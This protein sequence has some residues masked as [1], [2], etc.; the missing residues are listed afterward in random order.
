MITKSLYNLILKGK[1]TLIDVREKTELIKEGEISGAIHIP[2]REIENKIEK[3]N[4]M[5][6]P[7]ILFCRSGSRSARAIKFLEN[8][9]IKDLYNGMGFSSIL[10]ILKK[11]DNI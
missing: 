9:G 2:L 5:T 11:K 3:I 10:E 7:L 4:K 1:G 6:K 8:L